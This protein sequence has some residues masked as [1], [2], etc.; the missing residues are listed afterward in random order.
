MSC[1]KESRKV[2]FNSM[3]IYVL[4][5]WRTMLA[6]GVAVAVL[7]GAYSGVSYFFNWESNQAAFDE[8]QELYTED[9]AVYEMQKQ[10]YKAQLECY[11]KDIANQEAYLKESILMALDFK[12]NTQASA[13]ILVKLEKSDANAYGS[14][15]YDPADSV[16]S[17]FYNNMEYNTDWD[18]IAK[19]YNTEARY[20][21]EVVEFE[22]IYEANVLK[23]TVNHY[24]AKA[25]E[26]ILDEIIK[27]VVKQADF[28]SSTI[29]KH[30]ISVSKNET[31]SIIDTELFKT[32]REAQ[33]AAIKTFE[34]ISTTKA[35]K[36]S[37]VKPTLEA[38]A[39]SYKALVKN[40]IIFAILGGVVGV[41]AVAGI[42]AVIYCLG[43]KLHSKEE[44]ADVA[45]IKILGVIS[46]PKK[47]K[48]CK[49]TD[50]LIERLTYDEFKGDAEQKEKKIA[51]NITETIKT[52][53]KI[54]II[55]N[56][57]Q[58]QLDMAK[59]LIL[60]A[61]PKAEITLQKDIAKN[62]DLYGMIDNSEAIIAVEKIGN[63]KY[64]DIFTTEKL[65]A[66]KEKSIAGYI[67]F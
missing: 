25:A 51:Y 5:S 37:L 11:E 13:N 67:L 34:K 32:Q 8:A 46:T 30:G 31:K 21:Q 60:S 41:L 63:S 43:D 1:E 4:R 57:P 12:N 54:L 7:L 66:E 49:K 44:F 59:D 65:V 24:D 47:A 16:L 38:E 53:K 14:A 20:I 42:C 55:G 56:A 10:Q 58:A 26:G 52:A 28:F 2:K 45:G 40:V 27:D 33:E 50:A 23:I 29:F 18:A 35:A 15:A 6:V 3:L 64:T 36:E 61:A 19:L 9:L 62:V 22:P 17:L 48:F 39:S